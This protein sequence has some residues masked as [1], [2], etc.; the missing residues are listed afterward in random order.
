MKNISYYYNLLIL[1]FIFS[2][3]SCK[4]ENDKLPS[5]PVDITINIETEPSYLDLK[6]I[7]NSVP[8][9]GGVKG[10]YLYRKSQNQ[11][12]AFDRAC[13]FDPEGKC[14]RVI[15]EDGTHSSSIV[16]DTACNSRFILPADGLATE[17][18]QAKTS[19][20]EYTVYFNISNGVVRITN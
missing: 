8:I 15:W 16:V 12:Q 18:S 14:S 1:I 13:P 6:Y 19:L 10:I 4:D 3:L 5:V 9:T 20:R 11:I 2:F 17:D 7:G